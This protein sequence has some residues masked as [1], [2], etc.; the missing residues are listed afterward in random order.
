MVEVHRCV[1]A[2]DGRTRFWGDANPTADALAH[3]E[4][5]IGRVIAIQPPG[6]RYRRTRTRNQIVRAAYIGVRR[7]PRRLWYSRN[8]LLRRATREKRRSDGS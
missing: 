6:G 8:D 2:R 7:L 5:L 4:V 1:G 3:D